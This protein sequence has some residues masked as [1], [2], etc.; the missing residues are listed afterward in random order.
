VSSSFLA[1]IGFV[2]PQAGVLFASADTADRIDPSS[3]PS[4]KVGSTK[5]RLYLLQCIFNK[6]RMGILRV[7]KL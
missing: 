4:R 5:Y 7:A 1:V 2:S 3:P 6:T